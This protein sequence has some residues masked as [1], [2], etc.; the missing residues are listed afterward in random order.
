MR[1]NNGQRMIIA[2]VCI[3]M[4]AALL[5]G[6]GH[7]ALAALLKDLKGWQAEPATSM[8]MDA[9]GDT[10]TTATRSYTKGDTTFSATVVV[11]KGAYTQ[12]K[13]MDMR[14]E[15][16]GVKVQVSTIDGFKVQTTY[17]SADKSGAL[18]V[19]LVK[20]DKTSRGALATFAFNGMSEAD[21]LALAKQFDWKKLQAAALAI[22]Q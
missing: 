4:S 12:S 13:M 17:T 14:F 10:M 21:A 11:S 5:F 1:T 3:C 8:A 7:N 19:G 15:S 22:G 16:D 20:N 18:I 9:G 2:G 6:A